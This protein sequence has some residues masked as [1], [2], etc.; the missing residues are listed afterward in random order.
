M[1]EVDMAKLCG[2]KTRSGGTCKR[3]PLQGKTRCKLHGGASPGGAP[4]NSNARKHGIYSKKLS[5]EEKALWN[6]VELGSVDP[7]LRICRLRLM[8]AIRAERQMQSMPEMQVIERSTDK[9]TAAVVRKYKRYDYE[10]LVE[11]LIA[12][13]ESLEKTRLILLH[14]EHGARDQ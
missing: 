1:K 3:A 2:A 8:R 9:A 10:R 11:C 13:I 14:P 5:D 4:G 6:H 7:E 12:R